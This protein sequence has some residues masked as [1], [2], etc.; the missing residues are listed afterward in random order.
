MSSENQLGDGTGNTGSPSELLG[1]EASNPAA[2]WRAEVASRIHS[3]R[4]RNGEADG[5]DA[6]CALSRAAESYPAPSITE[7]TSPPEEM[8]R[9]EEP[10]VYPGELSER[11]LARLEE[12]RNAAHSAFDTN[13]YRRLNLETLSAVAEETAAQAARLAVDFDLQSAAE[14]DA[15]LER[16]YAAAEEATRRLDEFEEELELDSPDAPEA[17][18]PLE[19]EQGNLIVF[20]RP[21]LE[22]PLM[23]QPERDELAEPVAQRP[24]ILEVPE[25]IMPAV[26]GSLFPEIRLDGDESEADANESDLQIP[27]PVAPLTSRLLVALLDSAVVAS[28]GALFTA[29]ARDA[30]P[31]ISHAKPFWMAMAAVTVLLWA[32]YQQMFLLFAGRTF[33]MR[34][35][36]VRLASFDGSTPHWRQRRSRA[37]FLLISTATGMLGN[38]WALLDKN[39]LCWHDRLSQTFPTTEPRE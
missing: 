3:Y 37:L 32:L 35:L 34:L 4:A 1:D 27:V 20:P 36:G 8:E 39:T 29:I 31:Q 17:T 23:R 18:G 28:A 21:L 2:S 10:G 16:Y 15:G 19:E 14:R 9:D 5:Q 7:C 13:Y 24:R 6:A 22:P 25:D 11:T 12:I 33:G 26:Q 38:L 30:V